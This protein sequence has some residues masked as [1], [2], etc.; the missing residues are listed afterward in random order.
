MSGAVTKCTFTYSGSADSFT[1]PARVTTL[2]LDV[3]AA[4]GGRGCA[5]GDGGLGAEVQSTLSV[6]PGQ[7]LLINVGGKGGDATCGGIN[8]A[9]AGVGGFNGGAN[10]GIGGFAQEYAPGG[11]GGGAS[12]VRTAPYT[13]SDRLVIAGGG[14][15]G[16]AIGGNG[17]IPGGDG[18]G[19][20]QA[21]VTGQAG[22]AGTNST[23]GQGGGGGT[24]TAGGAGGSGGS[25]VGGSGVAGAAGARGAIATGGVG[26]ASSFETESGGG[27]GGGGL[28]GGGGG[29]EGAIAFGQ[30][31]PGLA[32]GGGG[33]GGSSAGPA[34]S[35]FTNSTFTG[36]GVVTITYSTPVAPL[37]VP[38]AA[39]LASG[40]VGSS[41]SAPTTTASPSGGVSPYTFGISSGSLP[42]GLTIDPSTGV[43]SGTPTSAGSSTF[44]VT[45]TDSNSPAASQSQD[46]TIN[47][48]QSA[49]TTTVTSS[50]NPSA[51][52]QT[53]TF[54]AT[55]TGTNPTGRVT[56]LDGGQQ[57]GL[58]D[59]DGNGQATFATSTLAVD[60]H[61]ITASY[62]GDANNAASTSAP[63][64]QTITQAAT[65]L[66]AR[67]ATM[68]R[69]GNILVI[70]GLSATLTSY[71]T[72]VS[73]RTITF[74][75]NAAIPAVLCTATTDATGTATCSPT[76]TAPSN[77]ISNLVNVLRKSGYRASFVGTTNYVSSS[78]VATVTQTS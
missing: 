46:F 76:I 34:G 72:P 58:A 26:G 2:F 37:S 78:A 50:Q 52:G 21:G 64:I 67:N 4:S 13:L 30:G 56:F 25:F 11:G 7:A 57:I 75:S 43:I 61:S 41:Y 54:T 62:R 36:N 42:A 74:Y 44:T 5:G 66:T 10:G 40:T 9:V 12:E 32:A 8:D 63:L 1:V 38:W 14:G 60:P 59:L 48:Q 27:G 29:G 39:S 70:N 3:K 6:T 20:G 68:T 73:G 69:R 18:G 19:G 53:V 31:G 16:G 47:V 55:V 49:T 71:N 65:A 77:Q 17:G 33:G 51:Y 15:G 35:I 22:A 45:V 24:S 28:Y 23:G